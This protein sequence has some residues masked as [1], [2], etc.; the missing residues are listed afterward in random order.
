MIGSINQILVEVHRSPQKAIPFFE[1]VQKKGYVNFHKES[2][3]LK[4]QCC[5][6]YSFLRLSKSFFQQ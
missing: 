3:M 1:T 2:T 6:N 5:Y 4:N